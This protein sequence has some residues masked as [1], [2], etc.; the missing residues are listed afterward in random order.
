M[1]GLLFNIDPISKPKN[2]LRSLN[3]Q[4]ATKK[5]IAIEEK[6]KQ[7]RAVLF[8]NRSLKREINRQKMIIWAL[9]EKIKTCCKTYK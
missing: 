5:T 7:I 3:G 4:F 2:K 9:E 1:D 8:E 6:A